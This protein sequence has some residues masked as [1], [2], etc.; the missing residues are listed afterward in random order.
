MQG[1]VPAQA[2]LGEYPGTTLA[3]ELLSVEISVSQERRLRSRTAMQSSPT[4]D[5]ALRRAEAG[6]NNTITTLFARDLSARKRAEAQKVALEAQL[7]ESQKMQAVGT[8]AGGIAHD[9]NN[10]L[11][12]ILGNVELAKQDAQHNPMAL[13]SLGEIDKAGRRARNL[14]RQILT[15]SRNEQ[16]TRIPMDLR[17]VVA[18]TVR[19]VRVTLPPAVDL[20]VVESAALSNVLAD[21]TQAE[22]A[23][24]NL[25][26]NAVLAI[27]QSGGAVTIRLENTELRAP[28]CGRIGVAPGDYVRVSVHDTGAGMSDAT[29]RRIFEPFFTTRQVGQGTGLGLSVVHGIMQ[30]H[31]GAVDV[32]STLGKGS[33]FSLYFPVCGEPAQPSVAEAPEP[34]AVQG[35]G[36][37]VVYLDDDQALVFLVE[38]LLRRKGFVVT[39]FTDPL[40]ARAALE[41]RAQ[42]FD[43]LVTDYN[44]PGYSGLELLRE[45]KRIRPALP[46]ALTSGYV[47]PEIEKQAFDAGASALFYKPN[48]VSELCELVQRLALGTDAA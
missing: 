2:L 18:E 16:P 29:M 24:L 38:R 33:V 22:Q 46:V 8:M 17:E 25:C 21:A 34:P 47:T 28:E 20:R 43:L 44:M 36:K 39:T 31:Q 23:L 4:D 32:Q 14:V 7:R 30:T 11:S 13:T 5:L 45:A 26:T 1:D 48:D 12:A 37:H 3:G 42:E 27:G 15:F 41:A 10:I 35:K 9:F 19:L 6:A 40:E